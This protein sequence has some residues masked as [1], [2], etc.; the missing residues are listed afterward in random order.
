[1]AQRCEGHEIAAVFDAFTH[2]LGNPQKPRP[3]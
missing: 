2:L 3:T 1:M